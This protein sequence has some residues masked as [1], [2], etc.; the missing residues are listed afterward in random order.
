M[1]NIIKYFSEIFMLKRQ[2]RSGFKLAGVPEVLCD[3]LGEHEIVQAKIA[4]VLALME[5]A[6]PAKCAL[7]SIFHD[8]GEIR[9]GD[10]HKVASRYFDRK[11]A[12]DA[13]LHEQLQNLPGDSENVIFSMIEEEGKRNTKEGI[14]ARDADWLEAALQ[15][16]IFIEQGYS[17]A[18]DWINNVEKALETKSA[19]EILAKIRQT[20]DFTN[21][22]WQGLKK[23]TYKKLEKK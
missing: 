2:K 5:G 15:A 9:I 6:D 21:V 20:K 23:M 3:S 16:K 10:Q 1:Q 7:I 18:E 19:K 17:G 14:I 12:E 13:A 4:Y 8:D 11:E 22:W